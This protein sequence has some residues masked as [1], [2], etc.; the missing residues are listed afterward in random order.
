MF[1]Q[2]RAMNTAKW[3]WISRS[4][5]R[6][7]DTAHTRRAGFTLVE[8]MMAMAV[9]T[10]LM[11]LLASILESS[12]NAY[13]GQQRRSSATV[14]SRAGL[15]IL[16]ADLR[17][18]C[19][20][21][22]DPTSTSDDFAPRFL[23]FQ[24]DSERGSDRFAFLR[25]SRLA[26]ASTQISTLADQGSLVLV[27]YAVGFTADTG[28][29]SSQKLYRRQYTPE[30]TYV[31][32]SEHLQLG[33]PMISDEDWKNV[34]NPPPPAAPSGSGPAVAPV[35]VSE[36]IVFQV[37]QFKVKPLAALLATPTDPLSLN[38]IAP[39]AGSTAWPTQ[40]RPAAVDLLLRVTN[41]G[42]AAKLNTAADWRAEG[43]FQP[44]L[45]GRPITPDVY[46]DDTEVETR[47]LR[48]HLPRL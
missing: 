20:P 47:Q 10:I 46:D 23:H 29:R 19:A 1:D 34:S 11:V 8:L 30:E 13:T 43:D 38:G 31:K 24:A 44:L 22:D 39:L 12:L 42:M 4:S 36:P 5:S 32:L 35:S 7:T 28:G 33:T 6:D 15:E 2:A 41:R 27:A 40:Q 48:I 17:S 3:T 16:R 18:Y 25:R 14:E 21:A 26:G 45:L 9:S 37:I